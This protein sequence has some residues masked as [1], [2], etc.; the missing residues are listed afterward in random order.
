VESVV[1]V[2]HLHSSCNGSLSI[3]SRAASN[4]PHP[5]PDIKYYDTDKS[6][7]ASILAVFKQVNPGIVI[8]TISPPPRSST[9]AEFQHINVVG[10]KNVI[11]D[12]QM[13]EVKALVYASSGSVP[14]RDLT[15]SLDNV[16]E[17]WP[18]NT[19][20]AQKDAYQRSKVRFPMTIPLLLSD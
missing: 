20:P 7:L 4:H 2:N 17:T 15:Q 16:D 11:E 5:F 9:E 12:C 3:L 14:Q 1:I 13:T 6:S 18:L 10:T 19:G 8:H